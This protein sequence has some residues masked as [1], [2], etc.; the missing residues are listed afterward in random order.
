MFIDRLPI[1]EIKLFITMEAGVSR[2]KSAILPWKPDNGRRQRGT[3][4]FLI[5]MLLLAVN[6]FVILTV[7]YEEEHIND[8]VSVHII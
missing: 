1:D 2:P 4:L 8:I 5:K 3:S 7:Y 6:S